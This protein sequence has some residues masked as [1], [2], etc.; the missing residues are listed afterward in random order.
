MAPTRN[1][2]ILYNEV[3]KGKD[4]LAQ[5]FPHSPVEYIRTGYPE[6]GK[7]TVYDDSQSIDL[8]GT[9]LDGGFLVKVLVMSIDPYM[10]GRMRDP[11]IKSYV[12]CSS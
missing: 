10:R 9:P 4:V 2:R 5:P 6:P 11:S 3:P 1:G 12:V 8:E 7:T